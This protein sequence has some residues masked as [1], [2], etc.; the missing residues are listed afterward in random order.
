MAEKVITNNN[1]IAKNT[2]FLYI[3]M[4][5]SLLVSLYT[6][7]IILNALGASDYGIYNVVGGVVSMFAF[8]SN[9]MATA[10][11]RFM[12]YAIGCNDIEDLRKT[13]VTSRIILQLIALVI[14]ILVE[15]I[16][17][18]LFYNQLSIPEGRQTAAFW[19][20]QFSVVAL[21]ITIISVPYNAAIIAHE[22]MS[23]YAGFSLID[24][25][26]RLAVAFLL[27]T[28]AELLDKLII[29]SAMMM[30]I[31]VLMRIIYTIYCKN[32]FEECSHNVIKYDRGKGAKMISFFSWNT[33]GSLSYVA[34]EQGVNI[35]IN[36]FFG[37]LVNAARGITTQVTGAVQGFISNFQVAMNPQI[38]KYYAQRDFK[39][40]F[41]LVMRGAKFSLFLFFFLALPLYI[42]I[43][44][45]LKLWL[46]NVPN[47][48]GSFIR[49][50]F[51]LMMIESLSAP[52]ITCLLAVGK[53]KWYQIIVGTMLMLNLPL[54]YIVLKCGYGPEFTIIIA[55]CISFV[56]LIVRLVMLNI[57]I[58]FPVCEFFINVGIKALVVVLGSYFV[59]SVLCAIIPM[60][61]IKHFI[62]VLMISWLTSAF[63]ILFW[64][65]DKSERKLIYS[66]VNNMLGK[67]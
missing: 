19:V 60:E 39:N 37:T 44:Y 38:V 34:K 10:T 36:I 12:S 54:S 61:G 26:L 7:R 18:W 56:S 41:E 57:Y 62:I 31:S 13:F 52:V 48:T 63:L 47:Y 6:S 24:I 21:F 8:M 45:V 32:Q 53:V 50:T 55:I 23:I 30:L 65:M 43:D 2:M 3:R 1:R 66:L 11:Q 35:L 16:G 42:E 20:F 29:Y 22:K 27:L 59:S 25:F 46:V 64:G 51:I 4:L 5:L 33:I 9:T 15:S 58:S 40:L 17:L 14:F 49:L 67:I 28:V